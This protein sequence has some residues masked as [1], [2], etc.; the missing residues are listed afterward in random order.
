MRPLSPELDRKFYAQYKEF[1]DHAEEKRRWNLKNDIPWAEVKSEALGEDLAA[2]VESFYAVEMYI[3]DYNAKLVRMFRN[4]SRGF[5]WFQLNWGYEESKHSRALE[6]WLIRSGHRNERQMEEF[7]DRLFQKEWDPPHTTPR[8][9]FC[10]T[11]TQELAT[12]VNYLGLEKLCREA[13]DP[14]LSKV[15]LL[16]AADEGNHHRFFADTVKL[17]MEDD[18]QGTIDDFAYVLSKFEM[19]AHHLIPNWARYGKLIEES[20]IYT[21]RVFV[22]RVLFPILER[23][24]ITRDE[25]KVA[26]E[27]IAA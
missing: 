2:I 8:Q 24:G 20:G 25:L 17:F 4:S 9:M 3:P 26:N 14:A 23:L 22:R 5:T 1:F 10:Y 7:A 18:R 6:E 12:Q 27:R 16:I 11:M 21:G 13:K 19:P 15:L